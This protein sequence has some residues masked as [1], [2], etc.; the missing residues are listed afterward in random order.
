MADSND[1]QK[2]LI[3]EIE[4]LQDK[5]REIQKKNEPFSWYGKI[6]KELKPSTILIVISILAGAIGIFVQFDNFIAQKKIENEIRV[7][8]NMF[9]LMDTIKSKDKTYEDREKNILLLTQYRM[10]AVPVLLLH[11][12]YNAEDSLLI[13]QSL[14]KIREK[15]DED[16]F[17]RTVTETVGIHFTNVLNERFNKEQITNGIIANIHVMN[18]L[19]LKKIDKNWFT[20]FGELFYKSEDEKVKSLYNDWYCILADLEKQSDEICD[21]DCKAAIVML[22]SKL[23]NTKSR[24]N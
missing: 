9:A 20:R 3:L 11:L 15:V 22:K 10:N 21:A 7:E 6:L 17:F 2:K 12:K 5:L 8:Y 13:E 16:I 1:E 14:I 24:C 19:F 18:K 4:V 23:Q